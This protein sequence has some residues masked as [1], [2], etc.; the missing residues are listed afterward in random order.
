MKI[1]SGWK[2]LAALGGIFVGFYFPEIIHFIKSL[3]G[4]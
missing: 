2:L 1:D 3:F 4:F